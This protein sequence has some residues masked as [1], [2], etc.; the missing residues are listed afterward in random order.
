MQELAL[1]LPTALLLAAVLALAVL[2]VRR[3]RRRGLCDCGDHGDGCG[4]CGSCAGCPS[5]GSCPAAEALIEK[6]GS[7]A[8][9]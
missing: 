1:N 9:R 5:K 3:M 6:A 2:A 4:S 8:S 7:P